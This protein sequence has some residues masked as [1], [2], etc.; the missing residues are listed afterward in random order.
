MV[1]LAFIQVIGD[2]Y[3]GHTI[4]GGICSVLP[5][6]KTSI[7]VCFFGFLCCKLVAKDLREVLGKHGLSAWAMQKRTGDFSP[8]LRG[9]FH[10]S[11]SG[12]FWFNIYD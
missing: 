4:E 3:V 7:G 12:N 1:F 11:R 9:A 6:A 8:V 2:Q 10:G 5:P